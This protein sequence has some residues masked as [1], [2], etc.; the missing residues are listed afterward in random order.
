VTV[1]FSRSLFH[2]LSSLAHKKS[3]KMF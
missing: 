1:G 2:E 3:G